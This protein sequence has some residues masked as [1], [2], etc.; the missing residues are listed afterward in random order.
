MRLGLLTSDQGNKNDALAL[1]KRSFGDYEQLAQAFPNDE[2][3][4]D[5][6]IF[7]LN[8]MGVLEIDLGQSD[9][10]LKTYERAMASL[11]DLI[12]KKPGDNQLRSR[13][14]ACYGNIANLNHIRL[15][16]DAKARRAYG[17]A[18]EIQKDLAAQPDSAWFQVRPGHDLQQSCS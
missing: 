7:C 9:A 1:L 3:I 8:N 18:L 15:N 2:Q 14:A 12:R 10:A 5:R 11:F 13:L 4:Q 6:L 16:D 17:Q